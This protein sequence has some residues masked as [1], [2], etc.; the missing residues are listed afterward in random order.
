MTTGLLWQC[1]HCAAYNPMGRYCS[2]GCAK[3]FA[4]AIR[5]HWQ[6][7]QSRRLRAQMKQQPEPVD[8]ALIP[9]LHPSRRAPHRYTSMRGPRLYISTP[10]RAH[11]RSSKVEIDL[12]HRKQLG[13]RRTEDAP[14]EV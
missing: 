9:H 7:V 2:A 4:S 11:D 13:E 10:R 5:A 1:Q 6:V 14:A 3:Q 12:D 8:G